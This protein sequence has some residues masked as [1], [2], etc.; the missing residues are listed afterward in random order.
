M[1][2]VSWEGAER[3][4]LSEGEKRLG[5][6]IEKYWVDSITLEPSTHGGLWNVRLDLRI[7]D[8]RRRRLVKV[9]MRLSPETGEPIEFRIEV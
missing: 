1:R 8:G 2:I 9:A 4:A 3:L 7:R 6:K 5:A